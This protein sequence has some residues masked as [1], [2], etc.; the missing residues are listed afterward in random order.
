MWVVCFQPLSL[1]PCMCSVFSCQ[2][3]RFNYQCPLLYMVFIASEWSS[4][5]TYHSMMNQF[6][7]RI[8]MVESPKCTRWREL[9]HLLPTDQNVCPSVK[10]RNSCF[11]SLIYPTYCCHLCGVAHMCRLF[12]KDHGG[13]ESWWH[14][15]APALSHFEFD[16]HPLPLLQFAS[17]LTPTQQVLV[18]AFFIFA[19]EDTSKW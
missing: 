4:S 18:S 15:V 8:C 10:G 9:R 3:Q 11:K 17:P 13:Y 1:H 6:W 14:R 19:L 12:W 5:R 2:H 16:S 7:V